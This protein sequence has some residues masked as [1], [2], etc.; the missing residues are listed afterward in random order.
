MRFLASGQPGAPADRLSRRH[1]TIW[2][3]SQPQ[4]V[5]HRAKGVAC[6]IRD[7]YCTNEVTAIDYHRRCGAR[8]MAGGLAQRAI[9]FG[10]V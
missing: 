8:P 3:D 7:R 10:P 9:D 6:M 1:Q 4:V 2:R 5:H